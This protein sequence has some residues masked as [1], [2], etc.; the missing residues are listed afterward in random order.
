MKIKDIKQSLGAVIITWTEIVFAA[1]SLI[2]FF[3]PFFKFTDVDGYVMTRL[4]QFSLLFGGSFQCGEISNQIVKCSGSFSFLA[5]LLV[6]V[7]LGLVLYFRKSIRPFF[8]YLFHAVLSA[9]FLFY[10]VST[11]AVA[12]GVVN[13]NPYVLNGYKLDMAWILVTL[14]TFAGLA[15]SVT[16]VV[17]D[18]YRLKNSQKTFE[19]Q[20]SAETEKAEDIEEIS[21]SAEDAGA[22]A[23]EDDEDE[24]DREDNLKDKDAED[25]EV[26]AS[27]TE[28]IAENSSEEKRPVAHISDE[29]SAIEL[30]NA[31]V[32]E[33]EEKEEP[34]KV[35]KI[36][37]KVKS[38]AAEKPAEEEQEQGENA[39]E[40]KNR[41]VS[42]KKRPQKGS[43][44]PQSNRANLLNE[45]FDG[46][47]GY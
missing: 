29:P 13:Q 15:V 1:V 16:L 42:D 14:L 46:N 40:Q 7:I 17:L 43:K 24:D 9:F 18:V 12:G 39:D 36:A 47:S 35:K 10:L 31:A 8:A 3:F 32:K 30:A 41:S 11:C 19:E 22:E 2:L 4:S 28:A 6:P 33:A 26:N 27:V 44:R 21:E 38:K 20:E 25:E 5:G 45:D 37:V 23:D 34:A